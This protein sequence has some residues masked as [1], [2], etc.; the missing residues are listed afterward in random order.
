MAV[1]IPSLA[2][3]CGGGG[4]SSAHVKG[5]LKD[6]YGAVINNP[7]AV[8]MLVGTSEVA[9]PGSNGSFLLSADPG[10]YTLRG[11]FLDVDA[12]IELVGSRQVQ[13]VRGETTDIGS[14]AISDMALENGWNAY[15]QEQFYAAENYFINYLDSVRSGQADLGGSSAYCG[16]G[17]TRG[18]GL[19]KPV[20]AAG[21]F[22]SALDGWSENTDAL[23][24]LAACELGRMKSD[25]GFHFNQAVDSINSA[26]DMP[27]QYSS[28]PTHDQINDIDLCAYRSFVNYLNG[29]TANARNEA[30][31]IK[32]EVD[33]SGNKGSSGLI[34]IVLAFTG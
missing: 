21:N 23:V 33:A 28:A 5:I 4:G 25:G 32:D 15:R 19:D 16:L 20:A 29:N 10:T 3:G 11:S 13:L 2:T 6:A 24:G 26:I 14:F 34:A 17:W 30:L 1:L 27:G 12:G 8:V 31:A 22:Q 7:N 18:R 9:H